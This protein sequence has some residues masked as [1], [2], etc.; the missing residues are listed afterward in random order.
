M[1]IGMLMKIFAS[2]LASGKIDGGL[3]VGEVIAPLFLSQ[4]KMF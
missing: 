1:I 2:G 4:L 3:I